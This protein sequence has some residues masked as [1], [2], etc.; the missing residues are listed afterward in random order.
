MDLEYSLDAN[1]AQR[2][3]AVLD[4]WQ[5]SF[6][7]F[8]KNILSDD[9]IAGAADPAE[10]RRAREHIRIFHETAPELFRTFLSLRV[11]P[12]V[13]EAAK[14]LAGRLTPGEHPG[15]KRSH[16]L[17]L[18]E[19]FIHRLDIE[20]ARE[21]TSILARVAGLTEHGRK[22]WLTLMAAATEHPLSDLAAAYLGRAARLLL[23]GFDVECIVICRAVLEAALS[24]RLESAALH[25]AGVRAS[26][27]KPDGQ[28][29]F[30][31]ADLIYGAVRLKV[32]DPDDHKRAKKIKQDGNDVLH[33]NPGLAGEAAAHVYQLSQLLR[34]VY[35]YRGP[36][37]ELT[38]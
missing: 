12:A 1:I 13:K 22:V 20:L 8:Y 37:P 17:N 19:P 23:L 7:E 5:D 34:K 4:E 30:S 16:L 28:H 10:A 21:F 36:G 18:S 27:T 2:L 14:D 31:L 32:F 24:E 29:E 6:D 15:G 9:A 33:V 25:R 35:P 11:T 3:Q 38:W 26:I